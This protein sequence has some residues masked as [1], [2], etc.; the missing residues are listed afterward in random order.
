MTERKIDYQKA[1]ESA[2]ARFLLLG[3]EESFPIL[4]ASR[5]LRSVRAERAHARSGA[6]RPGNRVAV[7]RRLV[8]MHGGEV[9]ARSTGLGFGSTFE[10]RLP[11]IARPVNATAAAAPFKAEPRRILVVDNNADAADSLAALLMFQGHQTEVAYSAKQALA[12]VEP[13]RRTSACSI[14]ACQT[15]TATNSRKRCAPFRG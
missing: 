1:F 11:R 14:S 5:S 12:C 15:W 3:T 8:D 2:P 9:S 6:G 7:V 13:S 10:I 4:D